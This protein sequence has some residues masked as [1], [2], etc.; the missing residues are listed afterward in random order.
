MDLSEAK[1]EIRQHLD[2]A[3]VIGQYVRL[4]R[5]G[6]RL[7][8]LCPFH[9]E[10]TPSFTVDPERGFYHCFGC[11][12]GGDIFSFV[13]KRENMTFPEAVR[14]LAQRAG[15]RIEND[16]MATE[17][18]KH[19]DQI[20]RANEI[21]CAHFVENL[22]RHPAAEHARSYVRARGFSRA[23]I[24]RFHL[25]FA[26]DSWDD[27]LGVLSAEGIN[28]TV[29]E[30]AGLA[31][32]SER[33]GHYDTFRNRLIFPIADV[34]GRVIAFGGRAL[35]AD[36]PAKYL[37]SPET[38][39]FQKRRT[40]YALDVARDAIIADKRALLVEGYTDVISLHQA[41]IHNVVAG[42][43]TAL[44]RE[45]LDLVG[46]YAEEVVLVYDADTA[47]A[48]AAL[49]NLEVVESAEIAAS[50][51]VLAENMDPDEFVRSY[52]PDAFRALLDQRISPIEYQLRMIFAE[53]AAGGPDGAAIAARD[54][55][56]VLLKIEDWPRRAEFV[57]RAADIWGR[58]DPG[59][60]EAME[61]VIKFE[62]TRRQ[63]GAAPARGKVVSPRDPTFITDALTRDPGGLMRA[64]TELLALALDDVEVAR[65]VVEFLTPEHMLTVQDAEILRAIGEQ[66]AVTDTLDVPALVDGLAEEGGLRRRGVELTVAHV[67]S[68]A[69]EDE[70]VRMAQTLQAVNRLRMHRQMGGATALRSFE[71]LFGSDDLV[72]EDFEELRRR[73]TDGINSG[74]LT[75][76]D[77]VVR[78]FVEASRRIRGAGAGGYVGDEVR[79]EAHPTDQRP[80]EAPDAK[81]CETPTLA[82]S[83][84]EAFSEA[85]VEGPPVDDPWAEE[86][87]DPFSLET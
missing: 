28:P 86:E 9:Q 74:E 64:E 52:G 30:E 16:P 40:L 42:L 58:D 13:M 35:D 15:I 5:A 31:K 67:P 53:H 77:E 73:I 17:K 63:E 69:E 37:N 10:K 43:G 36:N 2:I 59:R 4:E 79:R 76:E 51:I 56:D 83:A 57:K 85:E 39:A 65:V 87:G 3:E 8:G 66:L 34:T 12:E 62:L 27:L 44:T 24:D 81:G 32:P 18:R 25:G 22:F 54:A 71:E 47:G 29:A 1:E 48:R 75:L 33:G 78:K 84:T 11:G 20:Q 38:E 60:T 7:K 72:I 70:D 26:L 23:M 68:I 41:G 55:V 80:V 21:A 19:R 46:R 49:K 50:L 45:Q 6:T 82:E 14:M 61:R